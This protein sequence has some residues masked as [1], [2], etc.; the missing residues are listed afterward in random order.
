MA[1]AAEP[2]EKVSV[3]ARLKQFGVVMAYIARRDKVFVPLALSTFLLPFVIVTLLVTLAGYSALFWYP[4][5]FVVGLFATLIVLNTRFTKAQMKELDGQVGAAAGIIERMRGDWRVTPGVAVTTQEDMITLVVGRPGVILIGEG[6]GPRVRGMLGQEKRRLSKVIGTAQMRDL[7]V[8]NGEGE[9]PLK[10]LRITL[11]KMP[12]TISA[13]EV[14]ALSQRLRAL[15]AR[16]QMPKG[17][18]PK[19]LRPQGAQFRQPRPPRGR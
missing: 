7:I 12:R 6:Y 2:T 5:A 16:P 17:A 4:L 1:K 10:K 15:N 3:G 19:N 18:I 11:M 8:G 14:S 9:V 13:S